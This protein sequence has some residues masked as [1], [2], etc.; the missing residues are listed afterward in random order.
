MGSGIFEYAT[1]DEIFLSL[2]EMQHYEGILMI[3]RCTD[4]EILF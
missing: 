1:R 2:V 3:L 4:V